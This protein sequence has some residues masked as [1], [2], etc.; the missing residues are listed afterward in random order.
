[1][2]YINTS[3]ETLIKIKLG[4]KKEHGYLNQGIFSKI[5]INDKI[6]LKNNKNN[7]DV[8]VKIIGIKRY[9]TFVEM[10][11]LYGIENIIMDAENINEFLKKYYDLYKKDI[12]NNCGGIMLTFQPI[13]S[14][15]LSPFSYKGVN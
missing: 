7:F 1:M 2:N 11:S 15:S 4:I 14:I 13:S 8:L 6:L 5:K 12:K 9:D 10:A 3:L